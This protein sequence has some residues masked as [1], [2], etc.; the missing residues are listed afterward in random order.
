MHDHNRSL[1]ADLEKIQVENSALKIELASME[2]RQQHH[3]YAA[4][5]AAKG[6]G[7]GSG[8]GCG[9]SGGEEEEED[10]LRGKTPE[11]RM[12]IVTA[13]NRGRM[14]EALRALSEPTVSTPTSQS[15]QVEPPQQSP[16]QQQQQ[17]LSPPSRQSP[18]PSAQ[19]SPRSVEE[20]DQVPCRKCGENSADLGGS[21]AGK[22]DEEEETKEEKKKETR[23]VGIGVEDEDWKRCAIVEKVDASTETTTTTTEPTTTTTS[24]RSP[25]SPNQEEQKSERPLSPSSLQTPSGLASPNNGFATLPRSAAATAAAAAVGEGRGSGGASRRSSM[26]PSGSSRNI[27][28]DVEDSIKRQ[29]IAALELK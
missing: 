14:E 7:G 24:P 27:L 17:Q 11:Q 10:T 8:S 23:D 16:T 18:Q 1:S 22:P 3:A 5:A 12:E 26:T 9:G 2:M 4:A 19:Q 13:K 21:C 28:D 6:G 29:K 15:L 25:R 20:I